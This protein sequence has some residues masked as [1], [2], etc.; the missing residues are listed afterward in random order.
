MYSSIFFQIYFLGG[1]THNNYL[2]PPLRK[3]LSGLVP[4]H[5]ETVT[6][7]VAAEGIRTEHG[8]GR[9]RCERHSDDD[10]LIA[11]PLLS[12]PPQQQQFILLSAFSNRS[13]KTT[14]LQ[15]EY[16]LYVCILLEKY[17]CMYRKLH[18]HFILVAAPVRDVFGRHFGFYRGPASR[19]LC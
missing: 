5:S 18:V 6:Q 17:V 9:R 7:T 3:K 10:G 15:S 1:P 2:L 14:T 11:A 4:R 8:H 13:I 19:P 12:T 16:Y